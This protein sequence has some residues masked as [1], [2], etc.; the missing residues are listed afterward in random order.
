MIEPIQTSNIVSPLDQTKFVS[1]VKK[2][3]SQIT[4]ANLLEILG[5]QGVPSLPPSNGVRY[6]LTCT[7]GVLSWITDN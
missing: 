5:S 7:N 3:Q 6:R 4:R 1:E 2:F